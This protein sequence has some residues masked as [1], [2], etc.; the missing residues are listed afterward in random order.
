[1]KKINGNTFREMINTHR[2][3][4]TTFP[5]RMFSL[6]AHSFGF[7]ILAAPTKSRSSPG[8]SSWTDA[9]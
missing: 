5:I 8:D 6:L 4:F 3:N 1:V 2:Q 7:G 9:M